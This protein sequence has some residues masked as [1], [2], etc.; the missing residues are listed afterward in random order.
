MSC[1][2]A[3]PV[4]PGPEGLDFHGSIAFS[5]DH[6]CNAAKLILS[7][8]TWSVMWP[9]FGGFTGRI[10]KSLLMGKPSKTNP[11]SVS[12]LDVLFLHIFALPAFRS[13]LW[14]EPQHLHNDQMT[15]TREVRKGEKFQDANSI[16]LMSAS[17]TINRHRITRVWKAVVTATI[18]ISFCQPGLLRSNVAPSP[19]TLK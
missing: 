2:A 17:Y 3:L 11:N 1:T 19:R 15:R 18:L 16:Q 9:R 12:Q 10:W 4:T 13:R 14:P 5:I 6:D 7:C 8:R